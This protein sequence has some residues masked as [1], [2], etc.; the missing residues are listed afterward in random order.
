MNEE[1]FNLSVRTFLKT[2][3]V[4][5]QH[6]IEK[7]VANAMARSAISGTEKLPGKITLEILGLALKVEVNGDISLQ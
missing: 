2:F 7:A 5:A 3:G 6:E 4:Q 1:V